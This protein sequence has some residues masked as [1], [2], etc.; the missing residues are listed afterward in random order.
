MAAAGLLLVAGMA[1]LAVL[2]PALSPADP[3]GISLDERLEPPSPWHWAGT[4]QLGRD[5]LS[6]M[7]FGAR[8]SISVGFVAVGLATLVGVGVGAVAGYRGGWVDALLMRFVDIMLCFPSIFLILAAVAFVG[9]NTLNLIL[10]IGL[11]GWMGLARLVRAEV[12]SLK[13]REFILAARVMGLSTARIILR[14]LLPNAAAPIL[15]SATLGI[16]AAI[17]VESALSFLGIGIQPPT[18][19]WGNILTEGKQTLGVAWWLTLIPGA[20][21][22]LTVLGCNLLGEGIKRMGRG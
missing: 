8:I 10:I 6:R 9:P 7:L 1:L 2:A 12:L 3:A 18:P 17:L 19:S 13:E 5:V 16:G 22:F 11:T 21:I 14:H 20:S 4:D 15:V